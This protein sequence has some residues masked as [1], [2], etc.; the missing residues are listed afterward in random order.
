MLAKGPPKRDKDGNV[1]KDKSGKVVYE[2]YVIKV[3]NTINFSKSLHY[4]PFAYIRSEKDILKLVTTII[5]NTKGE[6]EKSS[7]DF[8]VKAEKLLYTALIAFIWYE[9]DE[10]EKNLEAL[11]AEKEELIGGDLV[12]ITTNDASLDT[13]EKLRDYAQ[14]YY[15]ENKL[16]WD[17]PIG[18]GAIYVDD[19]ETRYTW[20]ATRGIVKDRLSKDNTDYIVD[21]TNDIV[22]KDPYKAYT[23]LINLVAEETQK[24]P[25]FHINI[26]PIWVLLGCLVV[27]LIFV[28]AQLSGQVGKDTVK[29]ST[30]VKKDGVQLND[31]Q[32]V[33]LHSHVT[34]TKRTSDDDSGSSCS[35]TDDFGGSGGSH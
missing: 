6:G 21:E 17:Q 20:L 3:L 30:Y 12:L 13:M 33:F 4:N 26:S 16:G 18:S 1:I 11:I 32:D 5:A 25:M 34:R 29:K 9:G 14:N 10:E 19:W 2:P 24:S 15:K 28:V 35:G 23:R 31:K 22:N 27:S 7:E 8:W